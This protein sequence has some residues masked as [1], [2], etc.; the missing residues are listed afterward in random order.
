MDDI[1]FVQ[2]IEASKNFAHN[3]DDILL[4]QT[5]VG[6]RLHKTVHTSTLCEFH[7]N[8]DTRPIEIAAIVFRNVWAITKLRKEGDLALYAVHVIRVIRIEVNNL[9]GNDVS[10][11]AMNSF[12]NRAVRALSDCLQALIELVDGGLGHNLVSNQDVMKQVD[13]L[14]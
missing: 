4:L 8:P 12:M 9:E 6:R 2:I 13:W 14:G 11:G 5:I 1:G 3:D 10:G 7:H